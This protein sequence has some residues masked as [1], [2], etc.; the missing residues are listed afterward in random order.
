MKTNVSVCYINTSSMDVNL[1]TLQLMNTNFEK[2][3]I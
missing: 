1:F 3:N 2:L